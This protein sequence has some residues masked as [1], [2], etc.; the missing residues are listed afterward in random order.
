MPI[1]PSLAITA[2]AVLSFTGAMLGAVSND[3]RFADALAERAAVAIADAE[4]QPVTA[5]FTNA[6][7]L[8]T[9]HPLLSGGEDLNESIRDEVAKAVAAVPGIGGI[10]WSDG[11]MV[12]ESGAPILSPLHCQEDVQGLLTARTIR[13]EESSSA[14]LASSDALIDEVA[15]ALRPCLGSLIAITGHTD[16]SGPEPDNM[17]LSRER[18]QAVHEALVSRGIPADGMRADGVGSSQPLEGFAAE[19]PV[20]RRIEFS[21]VSTQRLLP[22]PIDTPGPR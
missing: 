2:G 18:A 8:P 20:N 11:T 1:R 17:E 4:G 9:R 5:D 15:A 22:T 6:I 10:S 16:A 3:G 12:A 21:V 14:I 7:G 19:D 13:F